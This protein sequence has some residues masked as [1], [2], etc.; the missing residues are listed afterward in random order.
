[1]SEKVFLRGVKVREIFEKVMRNEYENYDFTL[2]PASSRGQIRIL[3]NNQVSTEKKCDRSYKCVGERNGDSNTKVKCMYCL[4]DTT[5][6]DSWGIPITRK[7]Y[8]FYCIDIFCCQECQLAESIIR[9]KLEKSYQ[10]APSLCK[11]MRRIYSSEPLHPASDRRL[12]QVFNGSMTYEEFHK[13]HGT[14]TSSSHVIRDFDRKVDFRLGT[15][16]IEE[17]DE[18]DKIDP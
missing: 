6:G 13:S 14:F 12:L 16:Y 18:N 8:T 17:L 3:K 4:R 11:E 9:A 5:L 10:F 2:N 7:D 1:M 15:E